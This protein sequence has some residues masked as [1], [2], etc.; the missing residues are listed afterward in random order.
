MIMKQMIYLLTVG[1]LLLAGVGGVLVSADEVIEQAHTITINSMDERISVNEKS[2]VEIDPET[3]LGFYD[4]WVPTGATDVKVTIA[5]H[6]LQ[7]EKSE[8]NIYQC[9][10]STVNLTNISTIEVDLSY[11]LPSSTTSFSKTILR[12]SSSI[13]IRFNEKIIGSFTSASTGLILSV[14]LTMV[15]A[16]SSLFN[17]YIIILLVLLVIVVAVSVLFI[18]K[19]KQPAQSRSRSMESEDVL[20]TEYELLKDMLKQIE[21]FYRSEKI[22]DETYHKLKSYYKQQAVETMSALEKTGSKIKE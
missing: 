1:I 6:L 22:A 21:K 7:S 3:T 13:T 8:E 9:N 12:D 17:I 20:K 5:D 19:K 10:L 2:T 18:M 11:Y 4:V 14:P 15:E 16:E